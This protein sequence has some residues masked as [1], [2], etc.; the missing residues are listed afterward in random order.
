[1][2][3][4][5]LTTGTGD[6]LEQFDAEDVEAA[7]AHGRQLASRRQL[8]HVRYTQPGAALIVTYTVEQLRDERWSSVHCWVPMP[9]AMAPS[10]ATT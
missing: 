5:R 8:P 1:M 6:V 3:G 2:A 9:R 7:V 10:P 4:Y